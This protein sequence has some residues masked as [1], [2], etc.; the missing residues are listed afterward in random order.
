MITSLFWHVSLSN[1]AQQ[2]RRQLIGK[3]RREANDAIRLLRGGPTHIAGARELQGQ[4]QIWRA[5]IN[6]GNRRLI[7]RVDQ[8]RRR[9]IVLDILRRDEAYAKYP[10]PSDD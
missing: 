3:A 10:L 6:T 5:K 7:F 9:I 1:D 2:Q 4:P 8:E